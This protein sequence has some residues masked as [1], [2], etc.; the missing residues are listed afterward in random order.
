MH[1]GAS[2]QSER[3]Q[4][5]RQQRRRETMA[6]RAA[7]G[8]LPVPNL[9]HSRATRSHQRPAPRAARTPKQPAPKGPNGQ[10]MAIIR[11]NGNSQQLRPTEAEHLVNQGNRLPAQ[12]HRNHP[13]QPQQPKTAFMK[14]RDTLSTFPLLPPSTVRALPSKKE[15]YRHCF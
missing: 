6:P 14:A 12:G 5:Q 8:H 2:A 11:R 1:R 3:R 7:R 13:R 4:Q 15:D 9:P 10:S